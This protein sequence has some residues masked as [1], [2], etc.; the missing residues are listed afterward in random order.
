M[1]LK[2]SDGTNLAYRK[3]AGSNQGIIFLPEYMSDMHGKK[4]E[5]LYDYCKNNN[6]SYFII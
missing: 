2:L 5:Y 1:M 6:K 3:L 4:A